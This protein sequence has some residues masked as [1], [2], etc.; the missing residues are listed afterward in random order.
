MIAT[1]WLM[2]MLKV[3][4]DIFFSDDVSYKNRNFLS[5][6]SFSLSVLDLYKMNLI[7]HNLILI[8]IQLS[9]KAV[10]FLSNLVKGSKV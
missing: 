9:F 3:A 10:A 2:K 5:P 6:L 8:K 4:V 1:F 7:K